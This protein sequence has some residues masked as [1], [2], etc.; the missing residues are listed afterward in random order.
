METTYSKIKDVRI[1]KVDKNFKISLTP[2][3]SS[4]VRLLVYAIGQDFEEKIP[5]LKSSDG[6]IKDGGIVVSL[7]KG[8]RIQIDANLQRDSLGS[9]RIYAEEVA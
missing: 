6:T 1:F 9:Y 7:S 4:K 2:D 5:V 8:Q 3:A